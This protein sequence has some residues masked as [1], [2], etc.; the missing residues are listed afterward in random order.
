MR[1]TFC[2]QQLL[3]F[4]TMLLCSC[5]NPISRQA[6]EQVDPTLTL[7][8]V[9]ANP[10]AFLDRHMLL[11][12]AVTALQGDER[13][14]ILEVMEWRLARW[15]EPLYPDDAGRSFLVKTPQRLDPATCEPGTLVTLTGTVLGQEARSTGEQDDSVAVFALTEL[16]LWDIPFRYGIHSNASPHD[17]SYA[18]QDDDSRRSPYDPGYNPYPYTQYWYRDVNR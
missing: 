8:M 13:G 15:G 17:P 11:G 2:L 9:D 12:G 14:S 7:A 16:H 4:M 1:F 10:A 5:V 3:I 6:R 18:G